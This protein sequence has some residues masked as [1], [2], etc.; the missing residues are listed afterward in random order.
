MKV[1]KSKFARKWVQIKKLKL[2]STFIFPQWNV[3]S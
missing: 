2:K 1:Q 3:T